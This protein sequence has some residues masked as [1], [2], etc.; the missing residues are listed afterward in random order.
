MSAQNSS[1]LRQNLP[2]QIQSRQVMIQNQIM[3]NEFIGTYIFMFRLFDRKN[4]S[5]SRG[6]KKCSSSSWIF[7][8]NVTYVTL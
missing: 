3:P 4:P 5:K 1:F 6:P 7:D 8:Q 2:T